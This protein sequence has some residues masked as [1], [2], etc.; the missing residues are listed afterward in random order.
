MGGHYVWLP[1]GSTSIALIGDAPDMMKPLSYGKNPSD[2]VVY[3]FLYRSLIRYNPEDNTARADLAQCDLSHIEKIVCTLNPESKWSDNTLIRDDDVIATFQAFGSTGADIS[4]RPTFRD[5]RIV[6]EKGQIVF[7]NPD[8]DPK[9]LELLR[10]P[11]FRSDMIDQINTDRFSTGSYI[12]SG[13]YMF[14]EQVVDA[15]YSNERITLIR[16]PN[17]SGTLAWFDKIHFKFFKNASNIET[18][19]DTLGIIIPSAKNEPITLSDRF[20]EYP[21][22]TYEYFSVFF[23]TDRISKSLRNMLHWQIGTSMSGSTE[24]DHRVVNNIF[25]GNDPLLP[26]GNI[27]NFSDTMKK[28]GYMKRDDWVR[29]IDEISTTLTGGIIY[30]KPRFFT[31]REESNVLFLDSASGGVLLSGNFDASISSVIINGYQLK[32]FRPGNKK[33]SYRVSVEDGTIQ[34]GKNTYLLEGKIGTTP[35]STGEILTLYY[36]SDK[37]KLALYKKEIDDS[38]VARNNTPALIAEREREKTEKKNTALALDPLYY[39]DKSGKA[40]ELKVAYITGPQS[41]E[42][43][44]LAIEKT[45][46]NLSIMTN[47]MPLDPKTLQGMITSGKKDYD[48]LIAWV[49]AGETLTGIGRLFASSQAGKGVNFSNIESE[50]LDALFTDLRSATTPTEQKKIEKDIITIMESESFFLP[51]SSPVHSLYT[52]RNLK[53]VRTIS[54]IAGPMAI[55]DILEFASIR[56]AYVFDS[57]NKSF[58]GFWSWIGWLLF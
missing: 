19:E 31:N 47:L 44:A 42:T 29:T 50:K 14:S 3:R 39:Y 55:Y 49:S 32:E 27:G 23:Q 36:T 16:N 56:D 12:T 13:Q 5:T 48:I 40:F 17:T 53:W 9:V 41:T 46:K 11:I 26:R 34:E 37:E 24:S 52:D 4:L 51:I 21:Y 1:G 15:A 43:Y 6:S 18:A 30:D 22:S 54:V 8:R 28:N 20:R 10:Y 58:A 57:T 25:A 35:T 38:Y 45:L 7:Y 33:F 2:E